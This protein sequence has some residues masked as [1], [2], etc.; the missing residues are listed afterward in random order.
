MHE[1]HIE[2]K[3]WYERESGRTEQA[4]RILE[5]EESESESK[6]KRERESSQG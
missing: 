4:Q 6:L 5:E 3:Q 2:K 1:V